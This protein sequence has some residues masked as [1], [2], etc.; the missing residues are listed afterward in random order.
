MQVNGG[1]FAVVDLTTNGDAYNQ[2]MP[3]PI[4]AMAMTADGNTIYSPTNDLN[5]LTIN[6][7]NNG[8]T[9]SVTTSS[10]AITGISSS[11]TFTFCAIDATGSYLYTFNASAPTEIFYISI[12]SGDAT[13][14]TVP[15]TYPAPQNLIG[16]VGTS[17]GDYVYA[18]DET[19]G[20]YR[21]ETATNTVVEYFTPVN[22]STCTCSYNSMIISPDE[23][24]AYISVYQNQNSYFLIILDLATKSFSNQ[25]YDIMGPLAISSDG[26]YLFGIN[27][28]AVVEQST[29]SIISMNTAKPYAWVSIDSGIPSANPITAIA[30]GWVL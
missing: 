29:Q 12:A 27:Y 19:L 2:P 6:V 24:T 20:I 23:T 28:T 7:T 14:I 30:S 22:M 9:A 16:L 26:A 11:T 1:W 5:V 25:P 4:S 21:I 8:P 13:P 18:L 10:Q 3:H 17:S 15:S